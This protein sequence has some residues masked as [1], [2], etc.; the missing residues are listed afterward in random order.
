MEG[1]RFL[2]DPNFDTT[3]GGFLPRVSLPG[4]ALDALPQLDAILVTH[5]HADHLSFDSLDALPRNIPLYA[6]PAV[7][8]WLVKQGYTHSVP[9][10][11]GGYAS[12][13]DVRIRAAAATHKGNRYGVDR[14]RSAANMYL[15]ETK[16]VSCFFAGDTALVADTTNLVESHLTATG[17]V[18][19]FALLPIGHAPWWKPGFR[20]GH[21]TSADALTLFER[22]KA[23]YLIPYHWGTFNHV[24]STAFDAI[25]RLR[26][27]LET[28]HLSSAVMILE[29]GTTF[30]L[31]T[32]ES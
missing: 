6:P 2:T 11:P 30:I 5:A 29:P 1:K 28:F 9:L 27:A 25:D 23:R 17:R 14:W 15:L 4:I 8:R 7:T 24:T 31:P 10:A 18:L 32:P 22:L 20:K 21:L 26:L 19:D 16:S 12:V 13:G 3:L